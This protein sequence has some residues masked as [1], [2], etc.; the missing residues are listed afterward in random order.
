MTLITKHLPRGEGLA[1]TLLKRA[2]TLALAWPARAQTKFDATDSQGRALSVHLPEGTVLHDGDVLVGDDGTLVRVQALPQAVWVI[3]PCSAHGRPTDLLQAAYRLGSRHVAA[4]LEPQRL[5]V[6][7]GDPAL[8]SWLQA[9]HL[10][11]QLQELPF[12]PTPLS[13]PV[14][15]HSHHA[16]YT[17]DSDQAHQADHTPAK[18][19]IA[20][21]KLRSIPIATAAAHRHEHQHHE[22]C[23]HD[24]GQPPPAPAPEPQ[25]GHIHGPG[26]GHHHP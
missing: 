15:A 9:Q 25:T 26:C 12:D 5:L 4:A 11:V 17:H 23:G 7:A 13:L 6:A 1:A 22:G 21:A 20:S 14:S 10:D 3:T 8:A 18:T 2:P 19:D 16:H 24:H